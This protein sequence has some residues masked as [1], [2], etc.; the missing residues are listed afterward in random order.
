MEAAVA[1]RLDGVVPDEHLEKWCAIN[2][3]MN[4]APFEDLVLED[5]V[6][7]SEKWR[8]LEK[9]Y[10]D[11]GLDFRGC[12]AV[13]TPSGDFA[14]L[15]VLMNQRLEPWL[16]FQDDTGVDPEHRNKGL[17][18]WLKAAMLKRF[19]AEF[20][21]VTTIETGNAGTNEPMLNINVAMGFKE[22][23]MVNAWQ[24]DIATAREVLGV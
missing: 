9:G 22:A 15:T 16:G 7:S 12:A 24:G 3:V 6:M 4:S 10:V 17:G 8:S 5:T 23:L 19:V 14:G 11:R 18:R 21:D 1:E 2:D 20:P 13:H